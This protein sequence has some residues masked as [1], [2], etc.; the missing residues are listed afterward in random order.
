[1]LTTYTGSTLLWQNRETTP[2]LAYL[3]VRSPEDAQA[4]RKEIIPVMKTKTQA[5][6]TKI[7]NEKRLAGQGQKPLKQACA[8]T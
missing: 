4:L 3:Y 7:F 5:E 2:R 6:W 1:M 8:V